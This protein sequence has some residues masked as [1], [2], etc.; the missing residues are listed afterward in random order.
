VEFLATQPLTF[1]EA[2]DPL[3]ADHWR[4][5]IESKFELLNCIENQKTLFA[6]QQLLGDARA[7]WAIFNTTH[8]ANQV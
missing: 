2:G 5:T 6:A 7:W 8:P 1:V 3:E 4:R